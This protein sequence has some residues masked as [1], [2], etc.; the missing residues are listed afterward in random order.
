MAGGAAMAI[1]PLSKPA[2]PPPAA[3]AAA[4]AAALKAVAPPPV[5]CPSSVAE[6][7]QAVGEVIGDHMNC[8]ICQELIVACHAMPCGHM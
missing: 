5:A 6:A 3:T 2:A 4:T 7:K 1:V 8:T